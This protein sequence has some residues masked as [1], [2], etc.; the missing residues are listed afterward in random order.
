MVSTNEWFGINQKGQQSLFYTNKGCWNCGE[1]GHLARDCPH[2]KNEARIK[3]HCA[4]QKQQHRNDNHGH[5]QGGGGG[6]GGGGGSSAGGGGKQPN[7]PRTG[8]WTPP[9][10]GEHNKRWINH[11]NTTLRYWWHKDTSFWKVDKDQTGP[12][13]FD[14]QAHMNAQGAPAPAASI[15]VDTQ[16]T[17]QSTSTMSSGMPA[18]QQSGNVATGLVQAAA[19]AANLAAA[20]CTFEAS[21]KNL[22]DAFKNNS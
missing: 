6:G 22:L 9:S 12:P 1:D 5:K 7:I 17:Q 20:E 10:K 15:A 8:K 21:M 4:E 2:E 13:Y 3:Q 19:R 14:G 16:D 11:N 18:S